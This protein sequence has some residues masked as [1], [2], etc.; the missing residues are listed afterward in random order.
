MTAAF[1]A[2]FNIERPLHA[3]WEACRLPSESDPPRN[4]DASACRLPAFPSF[5]GQSGCAATVIESRP[6]QSLRLRKDDEPCRGTEIDIRIEPATAAGWPTRV[7]LRQSGFASWFLAAGDVVEAHWQHIVADFRL[8]L[9]HGV[10]VPGTIW[11][12]FGATVRE[13]PIGLELLAVTDAALASRCGMHEG[14][15]LLTIGPI[16]IHTIEQLWTV[17]ALLPAGTKTSAAWVRNGVRMA[18]SATI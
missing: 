17:L 15:L 6:Q 3:V 4:R 18:A 2:V 1:E 7:T 9:T 8:Y 13:T 10:D 12:D 11:G 16:R 5:D 14:D